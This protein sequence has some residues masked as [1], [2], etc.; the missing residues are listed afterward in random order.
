M[1]ASC[2][3]FRKKSPSIIVEYPAFLEASAKTGKNA[4]Q[5]FLRLAEIIM[6]YIDSKLAE[7]INN[8][9]KDNFHIRRF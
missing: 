3:A 1:L 2:A 5:A 8:R 9:P 6:D 4:Y 7:T